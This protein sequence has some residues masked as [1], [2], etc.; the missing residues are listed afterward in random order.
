MPFQTK[1]PSGWQNGPAGGTPLNATGLNN[2]E[3]RI[4]T[5]VTAVE[6]SVN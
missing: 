3:T 5:A 1:Q 4:G 2:L 6:R